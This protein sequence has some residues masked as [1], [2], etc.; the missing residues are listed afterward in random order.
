MTDQRLN[1][2]R[3]ACV[4]SVIAVAVATSASWWWRWKH[5]ARQTDNQW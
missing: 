1:Y 3:N 2:I 5:R 4:S